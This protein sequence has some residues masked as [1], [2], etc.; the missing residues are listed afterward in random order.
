MLE[1]TDRPHARWRVI[2]AES[3][4]YARVEA[5][6]VVIEEIEAGMRRWGRSRRRRPRIPGGP[7]LR[8]RGAPSLE[9]YPNSRAARRHGR[10]GD[11]LRRLR[12]QRRRSANSGEDPQKVLENASLEGVKSG[13]LDLSLH[14][15]SE[16]KEGG[17]VEVALSGPFE[18]GAKANSPS[19][20]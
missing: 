4:R 6:R 18:A 14:A 15:N 7:V 9:P 19:S 17:D 13:E 10:A 1:R 2:A 3:K 12:R 5:M 20:R 16:G 8:S 11:R